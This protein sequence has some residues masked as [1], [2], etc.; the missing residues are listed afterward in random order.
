MVIHGIIGLLLKLLVLL[1]AA[2][3]VYVFAVKEKGS[4]KAAGKALAWV[5]V[6]L[7]IFS[8]FGNFGKIMQHRHYREMGF[9]K[10]IRQDGKDQRIFKGKYWDK[11]QLPAKNESEEST[12]VK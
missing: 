6:V 3:V 1:S 12:E 7:A 8:A 4:L 9:D 11:S 5:L 2:Y 10:S